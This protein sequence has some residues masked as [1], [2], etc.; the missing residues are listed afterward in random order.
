MLGTS[1]QHP[2]N[3]TAPVGRDSPRGAGAGA[4]P[5]G[6][7]PP[8]QPGLSESDRGSRGCIKLCFVNDWSAGSVPVLSRP[9]LSKV[10]AW[11][12]RKD[13]REALLL[14][15][16]VVKGEQKGQR[17]Q[18]DGQLGSFGAGRGKGYLVTAASWLL[19][20]INMII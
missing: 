6:H 14:Y 15:F 18:N 9:L 2:L 13:K 19:C 16:R 10:P 20:K 3:P 8:G 12:P 7:Q 4:D 1:C 11:A 5:W 17:V